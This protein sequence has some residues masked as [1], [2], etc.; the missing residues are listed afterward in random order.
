[1][2]IPEWEENMNLK[3]AICC[4]QEAMNSEGISTEKGLGTEGF[5]FASTLIPVVNVDLIIINE[6]NFCFRGE[7]IHTVGQGGTFRVAVYG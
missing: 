7:T 2:C 3:Q 1:M 6:R 4:F 5:L